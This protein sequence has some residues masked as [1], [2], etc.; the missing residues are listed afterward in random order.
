MIGGC[1]LSVTFYD[2]A[3]LQKLNFWTEKTEMTVL[4][5]NETSRL[6]QVV[7]D[8]TN[9][10]PIKLPLICLSRSGG[11]Q[12]TNT[13]RQ[14][15]TYD[16]LKVAG[17]DGW[18]ISDTS[19]EVVAGPFTDYKSAC[20][21]QRYLIQSMKK[22]LYVYRVDGNVALLNAVPIQIDYQLDV[23]TRYLSEADAYMRNFVFNF[24][25]Y[26]VLQIQIPYNGIYIEHVA[27]VRISNNVED[28]SSIPERLIA[29]QFTRLALMI[30]IDDAYLWD[31]RIRNAVS[32]DSD[33][34][35][36]RIKESPSSQ[37]YIE[38]KV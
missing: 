27:T 22:Q 21:S 19:G 16:G 26:P 37:D 38:E 11:Y 6:F 24:I 14:P 9:D 29:G 20:Q 15:I 25:N 1:K 2:D 8:K 18:V 28:L 32:I 17:Y 34:L 13:N 5:V 12:I 36:I 35:N 30:N 3:L 31:T 33:G 4:G 10:S 7:A 23:Y